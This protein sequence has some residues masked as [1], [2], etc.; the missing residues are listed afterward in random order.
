M[1]Y[2]PKEVNNSFINKGINKSINDTVINKSINNSFIQISNF[3][4]F[5][6]CCFNSFNFKIS[7]CTVWVRR[8]VLKVHDRILQDLASPS[9]VP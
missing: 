3:R 2:L 7:L 5:E 4:G 9:H 1:R 8:H 6:I